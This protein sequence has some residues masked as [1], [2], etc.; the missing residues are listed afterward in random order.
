[1]TK[2]E[3]YLTETEV[4]RLLRPKPKKPLSRRTLI[5][6]RRLKKGPPWVKCG[7]EILYPQTGL[8]RW[9]ESNTVEP[10]GERGRR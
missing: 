5:L 7:Q 6:W 8:Y 1:M 2:L 4:G 9:L 3:G 10:A